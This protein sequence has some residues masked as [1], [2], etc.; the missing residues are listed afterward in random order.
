MKSSQLFGN[1]NNSGLCRCNSNNPMFH[2]KNRD[3]FGCY[4]GEDLTSP[5]NCE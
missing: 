2:A 3:E 5:E 1:K 4:R